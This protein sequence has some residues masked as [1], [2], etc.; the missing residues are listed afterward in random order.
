MYS[1]SPIVNKMLTI[2]SSLCCLGVHLHLFTCHFNFSATAYEIRFSEDS[3]LLRSN[4]STAH[5]VTYDL[6]PKKAGSP[7]KLSFTLFSIIKNGTTLFFAAKAEDKSFLK[8]ETSNII[9]VT[10]I[11]PKAPVP[12][13][14]DA[15]DTS[16]SGVNITAI[17]ISVTT[18]TMV[19]CLIA[20]VTMCSIKSRRV[21][22]A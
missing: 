17:V 10:K 6:S 18:V 8:S 19:A 3:D 20:S 12:S 5:L 9:Q 15:P 7:E 22:H 21:N 4:F 14:T 1:I 2:R 11:V 16:G 13:P